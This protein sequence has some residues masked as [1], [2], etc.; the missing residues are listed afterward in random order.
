MRREE[1]GKRRERARVVLGARKRERAPG[2]VGGGLWV[3]GLGG[4]G[5]E[6]KPK[7]RKQGEERGRR[8]HLREGARGWAV[9]LRGEG[10]REGKEENGPELWDKK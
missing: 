5:L 4:G 6:R 7:K 2:W 10:E 8:K 9:A 3:M 1:G